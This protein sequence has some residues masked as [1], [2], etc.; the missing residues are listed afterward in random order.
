MAVDEESRSAKQHDVEE[1]PTETAVR[2]LKRD[3]NSVVVAN[4]KF[5][6]RLRRHSRKL[7]QADRAALVTYARRDAEQT[8]SAIEDGERDIPEFSFPSEADWS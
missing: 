7:S 4:R 5:R 2:L 3:M 1:T 6:E 8:I